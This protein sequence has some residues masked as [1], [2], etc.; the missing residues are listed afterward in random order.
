MSDNFSEA[1]PRPWRLEKC[2]CGHP[3]CTQYVFANAGSRGLHKT[4]AD[5]AIAAI[6][7]YDAVMA[8]IRE[9]EAEIS[10][11]KEQLR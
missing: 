4:D 1:T 6:N 9:L 2:P 11:M 5:F 3:A 7:G 10:R 8:R